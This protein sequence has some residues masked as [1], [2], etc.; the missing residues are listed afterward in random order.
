MLRATFKV[1]ELRPLPSMPH[2][3]S[4]AN[5]ARTGNTLHDAGA[6]P[7]VPFFERRTAVR[8]FLG[9][10]AA[11]LCSSTIAEFSPFTNPGP[12]IAT[13]FAVAAAIVGTV[14]GTVAGTV[15]SFGSNTFLDLSGPAGTHVRACLA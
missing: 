3:S 6:L 7:I 8:F 15:T 9:T 1:L 10:L 5:P 12:E 14:L 11:F 13:F 4:K 2:S